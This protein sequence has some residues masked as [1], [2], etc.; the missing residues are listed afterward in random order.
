MAF[1]GEEMMGG[2]AATGGG[3]GFNFG[4]LFSNPM[5]LQMMATMGASLDPQGPAGA[6][7][8]MT[9]K[10][11]QNKQYMDMMKKLLGGGAKFTFDNKG[12]NIKGDKD[13]LSALKA[14]GEQSSSLA[15]WTSSLFPA[16]HSKDQ[17]KVGLLGA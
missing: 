11:I 10:W 8:G 12:F 9:N 16:G 17:T 1:G 2:T 15:D 7:G 5:V 13:V 6:I 4:S 14:P 3:A